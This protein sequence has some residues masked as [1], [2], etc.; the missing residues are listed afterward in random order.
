MSLKSE[1]LTTLASAK[2][3]LGIPAANTD[4][5][6][7]IEDLIDAAT[8]YIESETNRK[9]VKRNYNRSTKASASDDHAIT[10]VDDQLFY[11]FSGDGRSSF[12]ILPQYPVDDTATF[13]L[14]F[15]NQ[16]GSSVSG[17]ETWE[18][19]TY[20][21]WDSY[22]VD[23]DTGTIRI[24]NENLSK[25][26]FAFGDRNFRV[27]YTAGFAEPSGSGTPVAPW[28]PQDLQ[29]ACNE[30]VKN[31]FNDSDN[32]SMERIG[33]WTRAFDTKKESPFLGLTIAK[34]TAVSNLIV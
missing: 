17:N 11:R 6:T 14:E 21:L 2:L 29:R 1:A 28:V 10:G 32:L 20:V 26:F 30:L 34:Y 23:Y 8:D 15:L 12:H 5:D 9:L 31:M 16:R 4:D 24:V 3:S 18:S 13:L 33:D 27:T 22:V 19:N 7:L 25:G